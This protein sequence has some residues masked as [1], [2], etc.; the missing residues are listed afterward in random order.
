[1]LWPVPTNHSILFLT[2]QVPCSRRVG[3][4]VATS[5]PNYDGQVGQSSTVRTG[6]ADRKARPDQASGP[7]FRRSRRHSCRTRHPGGGSLPLS[8][9][10]DQRSF[11]QRGVEERHLQKLLKKTKIIPSRQYL[12]L[13]HQS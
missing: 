11:E 13:Y 1:M 7:H 5:R 6:Q 12:M 10:Y 4:S 9:Q 2:N 8:R 3:F